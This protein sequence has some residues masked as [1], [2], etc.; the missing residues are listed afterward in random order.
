[1]IIRVQLSTP[2]I[3]EGKF[4]NSF[5]LYIPDRFGSYYGPDGKETHPIES[6]TRHIKSFPEE[7]I[8]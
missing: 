3:S 7:Y 5:D 6:L 1:M 4:A 8:F 2:Y